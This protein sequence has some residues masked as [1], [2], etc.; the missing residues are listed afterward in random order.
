MYKLPSNVI[1]KTDTKFICPT[2]KT[3]PDVIH[4]DSTLVN[5][6]DEIIGL[7]SI[8]GKMYNLNVTAT[9]IISGL[10]CGLSVNSIALDLKKIVDVDVEELEKDI[11][12]YI[13]E[14]TEAGALEIF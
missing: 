3:I 14:L 13:T 6:L 5:D 11:D 12:A 4:S 7:L 10:L 8:D 2:G 1:F 9:S